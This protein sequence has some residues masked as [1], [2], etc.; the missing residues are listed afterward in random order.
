M[1]V[2]AR[3]DPNPSYLLH[4]DMQ[5]GGARVQ[6]PTRAGRRP[7][8]PAPLAFLLRLPR[9]PNLYALNQPRGSWSARSDVKAA[10]AWHHAWCG[11]DVVQD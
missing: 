8:L 6:R 2:A 1:G 10:R 9:R 11:G 7:M 5:R 3:V 4:E